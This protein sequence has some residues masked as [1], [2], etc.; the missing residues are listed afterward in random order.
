MA[1]E[2][3]TRQAPR[4]EDV[5]GSPETQA[6]SK[7][8]GGSNDALL[9]AEGIANELGI[10]KELARGNINTVTSREA[11]FEATGLEDTYQFEDKVFE[12]SFLADFGAGLFN[13]LVIDT[14]EGLANL[15]PTVAQALGS[16]AEFLD[17]WSTNVSEFFENQRA[18]YSDEAYNTIDEFGDINASNVATALGQGVGF[19]TA[20]IAG[21]GIASNMSK[22][23]KV[24]SR[25][26][27]TAKGLAAAAETAKVSGDVGRTIKAI[28]AANS[29]AGKTK[30]IIAA[31]QKGQQQASRVGTFLAGTTLMYPSIHKEA[32][33][34]GLDKGAAARFALGV[35]GLVSMT[36]GAALEWIGKIATKPLTNV[37]A[38]QASKKVLKNAANGDPIALMKMFVPEYTSALK[39]KMGVIMEGAAVEFGQEAGQTYIEEGAKQLYDTVYKGQDKGYFGSD[40]TTRKTFVEAIFGGAIGAVLGGVMA[41]GQRPD[42]LGNELSQEGMFGYINNAVSQNKKG[43]IDKVKQAITDLVVN[44][45]MTKTEGERATKVVDDLTA[46]ATKV[47]PTKIKDNVAKYQLYQLDALGNSTTAIQESFEEK[48][49]DKNPKIAADYKK[50]QGMIS[51]VQQAL[52]AEFDS[53][54]DTGQK[55]TGNKVAFDTKLEMYKSLMNDVAKSGVTEDEFKIRMEAITSLNDS[56]HAAKGSKENTVSVDGVDFPI[57]VVDTNMDKL[58][59][60]SEQLERKKITPEQFEKE[61]KDK[62]GLSSDQ[63]KVVAQFEFKQKYDLLKAQA[64]KTQAAQTQ[65]ATQ[66]GNKTSTTT[67]IQ[68]RI[69][70]TIS[71]IFGSEALF[72]FNENQPGK[73]VRGQF[74]PDN[75]GDQMFEAMNKTLK[76]EV[77]PTDEKEAARLFKEYAKVVHPDKNTQSDEHQVIAEAFFKAMQTAKDKGRVDILNE[78]KNKFDEELAALEGSQSTQAG[79]VGVNAKADIERRLNIKLDDLYWDSFQGVSIGQ[80]FR[81][82]GNLGNMN[83]PTK[84]YGYKLNNDYFTIGFNGATDGDMSFK[85][86]KKGN[87]GFIITTTKLG[88]S[89]NWTIN[90]LKQVKGISQLKI[91]KNNL[92]E[93]ELL[94]AVLETESKYDAE[95]A[96]L[97]TTQSGNKTKTSEKKQGKVKMKAYRTEGT[98]MGKLSQAHRGSGKYYGLDKFFSTGKKG[99]TFSEVELEIDKDT[100]LDLTESQKTGKET[101]ASV[102]YKEITDEARKR[103]EALPKNEVTTDTYNDLVRDVALEKGVT[104]VISYIEPGAPDIATMMNIGREYVDYSKPAALKGSQSTQAGSVGVGG[105]VDSKTYSARPNNQKIE[106]DEEY[107]KRRN[108]ERE[109]IEEEVESSSLDEVSK[110][111]DGYEDD[112]GIGL[113][114]DEKK[115]KKNKKGKGFK[116]FLNETPLSD[117]TKKVLNFIYDKFPK[118]SENVTFIIDQKTWDET[119]GNDKD[120]YN[121]FY[122][123]NGEG[124]IVILLNPKSYTDETVIHELIHAFTQVILDNPSSV[125]ERNYVE[126]IEKLFNEFKK[127][128]NVE[129]T[130]EYVFNDISEFITYTM[131]NT[132]FQKFLNSNEK[133]KTLFETFIGLIKSL[134]G[135]QEQTTVDKVIAATQNIIDI[136]DYSNI[137]K[138]V[139]KST[140]NKGQ[141]KA[142]KARS[143]AEGGTVIKPGVSELFESNPELANSVYEALGFGQESGNNITLYHGTANA[144]KGEFDISKSNTSDTIFLTDSET[145]ANE[146]SFNDEFR[147]DGVTYTVKASLEK[148]FDSNTD[149]AIKELEPLIRELVAENYT[150]KTGLNYRTDLKKINVG[151]RVIENPTQEDFVQHYL[152]R[153]KSNWRLMESPRVIEY[154]KTKGYDSF[155]IKERG[156]N[157]IA[158]FDKSK[159]KFEKYKNKAGEETIVKNKNKITPQQKQQALQQYSQYVEQT[160]KQDIEG[161]KE[162]VNNPVLQKTRFAE[163]SAANETIKNNPTLFNNIRNFFKAA[164]PNVSVEIVDSMMEKYG[165]DA[166]ASAYNNMINIQK[167]TALQSSIIHEYAEIYVASLGLDHPLVKMGMELVKGTEMHKRAIEAYPEL[168]AEGQLKEALMET[169]A[170]KGLA[171]LK[172]KFEGT[173][174]EKIMAW[175]K[176]FWNRIAGMFNSKNYNELDKLTKGLLNN[177][178]T[179]KTSSLSGVR[180]QKNYSSTKAAAGM[181]IQNTISK[182]RLAAIKNPDIDVNNPVL[183]RREIYE[184]LLQRYYTEKDPEKTTSDKIFENINLKED[185]NITDFFNA[186]QEKNEWL[187]NFINESIKS[188]TR[189]SK[190]TDRDLAEN[191]GIIKADSSNA[192]KANKGFSPSVRSVISS[193]VDNE[194]KAMPI[195]EVY[196]YVASVATS[197]LNAED[198]FRRIKQKTIDHPDNLIYDRVYNLLKHVGKEDRQ[199]LLYEMSNVRQNVSKKFGLSKEIDRITGIIKNKSYVKQLNKDYETST[200]AGNY[201]NNI[202]NFNDIEALENIFEDEMGWYQNFSLQA[203][204]QSNSEFAKRLSAVKITER[205]RTQYN[206]LLSLLIGNEVPKEYTDSLIDSGIDNAQKLLYRV[207]TNTPNY[208]FGKGALQEP[209]DINSTL[210]KIAQAVEGTEG[211]L[212]SYVNSN[213][214]NV[215]ST[216]VTH[217]MDDLARM[218]QAADPKRLE[219]AQMELFALEK[220]GTVAK[221]DIADLKKLIKQ[222]RKAIK[223]KDNYKKSELYKNNTILN[224]ADRNQGKINYFNADAIDNDGKVRELSEQSKNDIV[225]TQLIAFANDPSKST[226]SQQ[227]GIQ[228]DRPRSMFFEAPRLR[229]VALEQAYNDIINADQFLYKQYKKEVERKFNFKDKESIDKALERYRNTY[230]K[231]GLTKMDAEGNVRPPS[232][233]DINKR[234]KAIKRIVEASGLG[235]VA[236]RDE[237]G[238]LTGEVIPSVLAADHVNGENA[239]YKTEDEMYENFVRNESINRTHLNNLFQGPAVQRKSIEDHIKRALGT[240]STAMLTN[241]DK[242]V[243]TVVIKAKSKVAFDKKG[244]PINTSDSMSINGSRLHTHLAKE[245]GGFERL[246]SNIK[247]LL[248]QINPLTGKM[249]FLKMSTIGIVGKPGDNNLTRMTNAENTTGR[250]GYA[251]IAEIAFQ[252]E[253]LIGDKKYLKIVDEKAIKGNEGAD[254]VALDIDELMAIQKEEDPAKKAALLQSIIDNNSFELEYDGYRIPFKMHKD[255]SKVALKDQKAVVSTQ[256]T[257][258]ALNTGH[259]SDVIKLEKAIVKLLKKNLGLKKGDGYKTS[260]IYKKFKQTANIINGVLAGSEDSG[261]E[262]VVHLL[263]GIKQYNDSLDAE[264]K[265]MKVSLT[266]LRENNKDVTK[267]SAEVV[268]EITSLESKINAIESKKITALD[269]PNLKGMVEQYIGS[270]MTTTAARAEM[271]GNYLHM[272]PNYSNDLKAPTKIS[273]KMSE[274]QLTRFKSKIKKNEEKLERL[275]SNPN[276]LEENIKKQENYLSKL[277]AEYA[278][279][280][281]ETLTDF[282]V[283]VPWSMFGSSLEEAQAFL[284]KRKAEGKPVKVVVVRVPA[285]DAVSTFSAEVAYFIDGESNMAIVPDQ[286]VKM[287][288]ADHDGDKV[289][290]YREELTSDENGKTVEVESA[291]SELFWNMYNQIS[292]DEIRERQDNDLSTTEIEEILD[293]HGLRNAEGYSLEG[294]DDVAEVLS[295]YSFGAKAIGIEAVAGKLLSMFT[296]SNVSLKDSIT[297]KGVKYKAFVPDNQIAVAKIL[298][299]ALDMGNDPILLETG[300]NKY[301]IGAANTMLSLGVSL[302]D[303]ILMMRNPAIQDFINEVDADKSVFSKYSGK[304][305]DT[306][307]READKLAGITRTDLTM[308][309]ARAWSKGAGLQKK[310][311]DFF[312]VGQI[313]ATK[314]KEVSYFRVGKDA[315]TGKLIIVDENVGPNNSPVVDLI[316]SFLEFHFAAEEIKGVIPVI[317]MDNSMPKSSEELR[318][319]LEAFEKLR[320]GRLIDFTPLLERPLAQHYESVLDLM[321]DLEQTHFATEKGSYGAEG[322][323]NMINEIERAFK[324]DYSNRNKIVDTFTRMVAQ[325]ESPV[326]QPAKFEKTFVS[327]LT[328]IL[329][330]IKEGALVHA[331]KDYNDLLSYHNSGNTEEYNKLIQWMENHLNELDRIK[332]RND[333]KEWISFNDGILNSIKDPNNMFINAITIE[334]NKQGVSSVV[335]K[336]GYRLQGEHIKEQI[337][338]DF[339]KIMD[340]PLGQDFI[341]Y[342]MLKNGVSDKIGSL[343]DM[344]PREI[345]IRYLRKMSMIKDS[346]TVP[347]VKLTSTGIQVISEDYG[348][349]KAE[350]NPTETEKKADIDLI[351]EHISKQTFKENVGQYANEMFHYSLRWG[352][353][354]YNFF[355]LKDGKYIKS[356][357]NNEGSQLYSKDK[358]GAF[359]KSNRTDKAAYNNGLLNPLDIDSFA[360]KNDMYGYDLVDQNGNPLPSIKDLQ[361]I[362]DKIE[363]AIGIDMKDYDSVI[364]NIYLPGEYVYPHKDT[365]ESKSAKKYPVIVYSI[366]ND[367]G[368]GIVDN[369]EGKMTFA[370]QYDE[371]FLPENDKLKGYTNEILTKHGSI[372]TFGMDGKGRFEL[373]HSTPINSKKD[374]P[375]TP[376]TLP[377]GKVV[378][379]YTIT[380]TFRRAADLEPGMPSAPAKINTQKATSVKPTDFT[381]YHG[382]AKKYDTYWEQEGKTFG[383]T[384]HTVYTVDSYDKLDQ[385]TKDKL[386]A[387]YDAARTWLGRSSLSKDT[388][389][390][391]LV[392]RDMMQAA[393]ADG[394]FAV[395]EIVAPGIKGRKGYVNKTS[396]PIIEGGTGYAVASG[397]LLGKPVYVFN[398]DSN[399][400]YDTGWYKWDSTTNDFVKTDTPV[401]TKNYAG[402]GSSTNETEIGTQAIRDVYANTFKPTQPSTSVKTVSAQPNFRQ[403]YKLNALMYNK[404]DLPKAMISNYGTWLNQGW[405]RDKNDN[406]IYAYKGASSTLGVEHIRALGYYNENKITRFDP[407]ATLTKENYEKLKNQCKK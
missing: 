253:E 260:S 194:G 236:V 28:E 206:Q 187:K 189:V 248:F 370:N 45:K 60:L 330:Y 293:K 332:F 128:K 214:E 9:A 3:V 144:F 143:L 183:L 30:N 102:K 405:S 226:Y 291:A 114:S 36:E 68:K 307:S 366:G 131:T 16:E 113:P 326:S 10:S 250:T 399:Y 249:A 228:G 243:V 175:L 213:G 99:E 12:Q 25:A 169:I 2:E 199:M 29:F 304:F 246:G 259:A 369:N 341:S 190:V 256:A 344:M 272:V 138:R 361:P 74:I 277:K 205:T 384:K 392:R 39:G 381:N 191:E 328:N 390:G 185:A 72:D 289:F 338:Q 234:V 90:N 297:Y 261:K 21:G 73:V 263:D 172:T 71:K 133:T 81:G 275:K 388:Y 96:A 61:L 41:G 282:E 333:V 276:S 58:L 176:R 56:V 251:E 231:S 64:V 219:E 53:I 44:G 31:A 162:F 339:L 117:K 166:L 311:E 325:G 283:A 35:S 230:N 46:F 362:I 281:K 278:S 164:F 92:N 273:V 204:T 121:G 400:G 153:A 129:N 355:V 348:V 268:K 82:E 329:E 65:Q 104:G 168:S 294:H 149:E 170:L 156:A 62:F 103:L 196:R 318:K 387:K 165:F 5:L 188:V 244:N 225:I 124:G 262:S 198:F 38:S 403:S 13:G 66:T 301:T 146:F 404:S 359:I 227:Y 287:S 193:I 155:T 254:V 257:K 202:K 280:V 316:K 140:S 210:S 274:N 59:D 298:Q 331:N 174:T 33:E 360:E 373:T 18:V 376:I 87:N 154:L 43:N 352:R 107:E 284:N 407:N 350:T 112:G 292:S 269:H 264:T 108:K 393:K 145:F 208:K 150:Y 353:K 212:N 396:H 89:G 288:D 351:K 20:I 95:L 80:L 4:Y 152:W 161:F 7:A 334:T 374:K 54:Y 101:K 224:L 364:G 83:V 141:A 342:Q 75:L 134:F 279:G 232:Q 354:S 377:N 216:S 100:T 98:G 203:V 223:Y 211:L 358:Y 157:N 385:A 8:S 70:D 233:E 84:I 180:F 322:K 383:V 368:L 127:I 406:V 401:L 111:L 50:K 382:G 270:A 220:S 139:L 48:A 309:A 126:T 242:P 356:T 310:G 308:S 77:V 215:T 119:L 285:S 321:V 394:I 313:Y 86:F 247:D 389:A 116:S 160:G 109:S 195:N 317:Q 357:L 52:Q 88:S 26:G 11:P 235:E 299:A 120:L 346:G 391:K 159:V 241:I 347:K 379:N 57:D 380:L 324:K 118:I 178:T 93:N 345:S 323:N 335:P 122:A 142:I 200:T 363:A 295:K 402:I 305:E 245:V 173:T 37:I 97:E 303:V 69:N 14:G 222:L 237:E 85:I 217:W 371:R 192:I 207:A 148:T 365:S 78:L 337:R 375:Q 171:Q 184:V 27:K 79:S 19:L 315:E 106:T 32:I 91:D 286:F 158:V 300:I 312:K 42:S 397:I 320:S 6:L 130:H 229:G 125:E 306:L 67:S 265:D 201:L 296:Q 147:P 395:S 23:A 17:A 336:K 179:Y 271:A 177:R 151:E 302:E 218:Y 267:R 319:A 49:N 135:I 372:Y 340:T 367:A 238:E 255:L 136:T 343:I 24:L 239:L 349:V 115:D 258:I 327:R 132:E 167:D 240:N 209:L 34:A 1:Q 76:G 182:I 47:R 398:Q 123:D 290:V 15:V 105:D 181:Y 386:D 94:N 22:G 252:L 163:V 137:Q 197:S 221:E 266:A 55:Q 51:S 63:A 110:E 314:D 378:T 40:V 186:I